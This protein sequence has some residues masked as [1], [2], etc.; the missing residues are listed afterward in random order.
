MTS[1]TLT[2]PLERVLTWINTQVRPRPVRIDPK[3]PFRNGGPSDDL[4]L[5]I[6]RDTLPE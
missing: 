4:G 2:K 3:M 6:L 1:V 5:L